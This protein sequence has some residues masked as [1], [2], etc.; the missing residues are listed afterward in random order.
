MRALN[1]SFSPECCVAIPHLTFTRQILITVG[2]RTM[3]ETTKT[4]EATRKASDNATRADH[5][6]VEAAGKAT[7]DTVSESAKAMENGADQ[8]GQIAHTMT[9]SVA[10]TADAATM[11]SSKVAEQ[12]REAMMMA[13]RTAAGVG[14][15][16]ADI[17]FGSSHRLLSSTATAMDIYRDASERSA[18][19]VH[20][21]FTSYMSLGRGL[22]QLQHAWLEMVDQSLEHAARKPQDLL[23]CKNLVE[24]AEVQRDLYLDTVNYAVESGSRLLE[25]A[26]RTALEAARP[27]QNGRH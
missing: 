5:A 6:A 23:R 18:E 24:L 2:A 12:G 13:A 26:S 8:V 22:Q 10:K 14:G 7:K 3:S 17:S 25:L 20:A 11:I 1:Y 9:D 15:R 4:A 27:L 21:L 19:R 16:V